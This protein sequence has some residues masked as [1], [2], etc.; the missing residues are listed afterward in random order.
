[1]EKTGR[2]SPLAL[3]AAAAGP[4]AVPA[5]YGLQ[6]VARVHDPN[7]LAFLNSADAQWSQTFPQ[8]HPYPETSIARRM[9]PLEPISLRGKLAYYCFDTATPVLAGSWS[10][11]LRSAHS[12]LAGIEALAA[13]A[14]SVFRSVGLQG[15]MPA[16]TT[17]AVTVS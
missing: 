12:T 4:V 3:E 11:A 15:T 8:T 1:M 9:R 17:T 7:L 13:G 16:A 10:S 14:S 6:P 2:P 5:D